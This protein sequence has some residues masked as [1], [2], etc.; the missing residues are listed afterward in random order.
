[1]TKTE[2]ILKENL[3]FFRKQKGK[4]KYAVSKELNIEQAYYYRLE[5]IGQKIQPRYEM[6]EHLA[7][8][9]GVEVFELFKEH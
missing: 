8:Y 4:T 5:S 7:T 6:L 9:Y 2:R 3:A 1:M